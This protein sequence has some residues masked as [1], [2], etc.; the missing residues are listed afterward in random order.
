MGLK[1]VAQW[2]LIHSSP[3]GFEIKMLYN[4]YDKM[5][6]GYTEEGAIGVVKGYYKGYFSTIKDEVHDALENSPITAYP[7]YLAKKEGEYVGEKEGYN[8]ASTEY[9]DKIDN[10]KQSFS[11]QK[12]EKEREIDELNSIIDGYED[13]LS[14]RKN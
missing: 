4:M 1:E 3:I 2:T 6:E 10:L 5:K 7:Y 9:E 13:E 11:E 8:K 12:K 14:K